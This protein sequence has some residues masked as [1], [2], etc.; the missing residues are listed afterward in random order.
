MSALFTSNQILSDHRL[1]A[2]GTRAGNRYV[3]CL[4]NGVV[5]SQISIIVH[6][7]F[8][9]IMSV[10]HIFGHFAL[11]GGIRTTIVNKKGVDIWCF[12]YDTSFT[13]AAGS[14]HS[15]RLRIYSSPQ[16]VTPLANDTVVL[17]LAKAFLPANETALLECIHIFP[18]PGIPSSPDYQDHIPD[19]IVPIVLGTGLVKS[20]AS[21]SEPN[22]G[23]ISTRT[24]DFDTSQYLMDRPHTTLAR[25]AVGRY[26]IFS[27]C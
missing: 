14:V 9:H 8:V 22:T 23:G 21:S 27:N 18:I 4:F 16:D 24:F 13:T 2:F 5:F 26:S 12:L 25:Y 7:P 15:A 1:C 20:T 11:S 10:F 19:L 3:F 6:Q 17:M